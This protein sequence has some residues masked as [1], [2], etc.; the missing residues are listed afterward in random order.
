[1]WFIP[2]D[3]VS[4]ASDLPSFLDSRKG[5]GPRQG[6]PQTAERKQRFRDRGQVQKD[7]AKA[8]EGCERA[9]GNAEPEEE[10]RVPR[11]GFLRLEHDAQHQTNKQEPESAEAAK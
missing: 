11:A 7:Q 10:E 6:Q 9:E 5:V 8:A 1:L 3:G 2:G 4:R